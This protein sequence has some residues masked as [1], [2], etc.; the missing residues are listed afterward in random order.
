MPTEHGDNLRAFRSFID[1]QLADGD[2]GPLLL[3]CQLDDHGGNLL[4]GIL[5]G[6]HSR[7]LGAPAASQ[8]VYGVA[9][10]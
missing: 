4:P 8:P 9:P 10:K 5:P 3:F 6:P 7:S 1:E 2:E